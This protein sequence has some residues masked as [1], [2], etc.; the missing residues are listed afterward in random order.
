MHKRNTFIYLLLVAAL[1]GCE[2]DGLYDESLNAGNIQTL[3]SGIVVERLDDAG[4]YYLDGNIKEPTLTR[5]FTPVAGEK[6][7]WTKAGPEKEAPTQLFVMTAPVNLRDTTVDER[8]YRV[9]TNGK[10]PTVYDIKTPFDKITF[11]PEKRFAILYHGAADAAAGLYNPNEVA[12]VDLS[13]K[14]SKSNPRVMSVSMDGRRIDMVSF[15][16]SLH[17][18]GTERQ[19]A[20]FLA[21]S[22][23]RIIDLAAPEDTW[24]KVPLLPSSDSQS[25][26]AAQLI[27]LD[28]T[29]GCENAS[30]ESKLFIRTPTT[31]DIY[32][33]SLGRSPDGFEGVQTKQLEAGGYP[34]ATAVVHDGETTLM[35]VL[36]ASSGLSKLNLI[37][38]D[39]SASFSITEQDNLNAM[40]LLADDEAGDKLVLWGTNSR[41]VYFVSTTDLMKEK[42]RNVSVFPIQGGIDY[43]RELS[44]NRLLI[45]PNATDL[46]LLDMATEKASMLSSSGA[47]DWAGAQIHK[48]MFYVLPQTLDRVDYYDLE[49]GRPDSLLLDDLGASMHLLPGR[50]TGI[51]WHNNAAGRVTI[52]PLDTPTRARSLVL[53]GLWLSGS[54]NAKG[55]N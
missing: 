53:D 48:D 10:A 32:Y 51:I 38:I 55:E 4:L 15:I 35:A 54:L 33:I 39:T 46:V 12:L 22:V 50:N 18:G 6:I 42:G 36:S 29:P 45:I 26:V 43:V 52:F 20:V 37:D 24:A 27:A 13:A 49:G 34:S 19:L 14:P 23:A 44:E 11:D 8:L 16:A 1:F 3:K 25:F 47:Y 40:K 41:A 30:C 9:T 21:G 17:I 31:Q 28:E 5:V 2:S 7:V